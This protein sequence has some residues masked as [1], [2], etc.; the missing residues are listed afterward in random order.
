MRYFLQAASLLLL[1]L[2]STLLFLAVFLLTHNTF[3]AVGLGMTLGL[4]QIAIQFVRRKTI[5][6]MEWLSLFLVVTAGTATLL[7]DD[8]RFLLFKPSVI[9]VIVGIVMLKPGWM[10]RYLPAIVR[11]VAPDVG[12]KVGY[13]WA[14]LMFVS[15]AVNAFVALAWSVQ[16]WAMVM[17]LFGIVSKVA[18]FGLGFAAIR[19]V[20]RRRIHAMPAPEREA[21]LRATGRSEQPLTEARA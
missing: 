11:T 6:A 16:T 21:L 1:D 5:D 2:A 18:V 19:L 3:L 17:P 10:N 7:T 20:T 13:V 12:V 4:T 14:G 15:A 8:P 9:Y